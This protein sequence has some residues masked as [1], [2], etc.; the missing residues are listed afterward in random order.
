[1]DELRLHV[2]QHALVVGDQQHAHLGREGGVDAR[3]HVL[4]RV[5]VEAR[6]G[7]VQDGHRRIEHRHLE[8]LEPLLLAAREALVDV[9]RREGRI[10]AEEGHLLLHELPEL[11]ERNAGVLDRR[12]AGLVRRLGMVDGVV[13]VAQEAGDGHARDGARIL[14]GEEEAQACALVGRH[15]QRRRPGEQVMAGPGDRA[16]VHDVVG[17]PHQGIGQAGLARAVRAHQGMHLALPDGQVEPLEDLLGADAH[18]EPGD[19]Q[20]VG[21][22]FLASP[23]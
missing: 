4:E 23:V 3:R 7:L 1:M 10:H 14:E 9:A 21:H 17:V 22:A 19:H 13:D 8:H 11:G 20:F 16:R 15:A 5:D 6:I 2:V 18:L 12:L